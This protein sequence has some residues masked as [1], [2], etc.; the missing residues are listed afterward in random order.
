[1]AARRDELPPCRGSRGGAGAPGRIRIDAGTLTA[2]GTITPT[3]QLGKPL[4][5][6]PL[7]VQVLQTDA[8]HLA[9]LNPSPVPVDVRV[10]VAKP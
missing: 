1:M 4:A 2:T 10:V 9:V 5:A 8:D 3:Q 6:V 7:Y